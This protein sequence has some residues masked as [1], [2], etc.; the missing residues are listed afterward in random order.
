MTD[1]RE[2]RELLK[3]YGQRGMEADLTTRKPSTDDILRGMSD[4]DA[5]YQLLTLIDL[6]ERARADTGFAEGDLVRVRRSSWYLGNSAR[7]PGWMGFSQ[8]F[9][10]EVAVLTRLRWNPHH[11]FWAADL[12]YPT[13]YRYSDYLGGTFWVR[14]RSVTFSFDIERIKKVHEHG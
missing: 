5:N 8:M 13:E 12:T 1:I 9:A 10:D 3:I 6:Y 14:D 4:V 7:S 2:T 11:G